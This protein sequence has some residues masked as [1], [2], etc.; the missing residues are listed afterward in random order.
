MAFYVVDF[1]Q[2]KDEEEFSRWAECLAN[3][4]VNLVSLF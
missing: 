2:S 3:P 4:S 1:G